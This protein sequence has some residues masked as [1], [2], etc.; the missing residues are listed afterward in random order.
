MI[1]ECGLIGLVGYGYYLYKTIDKRGL[2]NDFNKSME[3]IGLYNKNKETF[4][5]NSL[6][7]TEYGW[8][9]KI[10]IPKG[11]SVEHLN[12]KKNILEDN[13]NSIIEIEKD[14]FKDYI[15]IYIINRDVN[16]Y[17]FKPVKSKP[18]E[19]YIGKDF[20]LKD[21]K[22]NTRKDCHILIGGVTGTGKTFLLASI[23][24]NLIYNSSN[25]IEIYLLQ[26]AKSELSAF[27]NCNC[28]KESCFDINSCMN[29]LNKIKEIINKRSEKFKNNGIRNIQQWN[30]HYKKE[31]MKEIYV[32]IE[33]LSFFL[34]CQPIT[35]ISKVGRSVGVHIIS[36]IQRTV[37]TEMDSTLKS[38]M[39]RIT[40]HQKSSIDSTNIIGTNDAVLLKERECIVDGN[41]D[42]KRIKTPWIDE[43]YKIL[44]RYVPQIKI[45][46]NYEKV[47]KNTENSDIIVQKVVKTNK[48]FKEQKIL[49][50]E[51]HSIIDVKEED[52]K[53]EK[54]KKNN[55]KFKTGTISLEEFNNVKIQR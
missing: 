14:N 21:F 10:H 6:K 46:Q 47:S 43:D 20:Q 28:V 16:K 26:V 33:E 34:D 44:N 32:I 31:Y 55:K 1:V 30:K 15:N 27:E 4:L 35:E 42:Y 54:P 52:I 38:Q 51:E 22:L 11:L 36:C 3:G 40:F 12:S 5:L 2:I 45:P 48:N 25:K 37:R 53:E 7:Q 13:L 49:T 18:Y 24:T 50:I 9:G 29:L 41:N 39:S 23:L 17:E 8:S 19:I